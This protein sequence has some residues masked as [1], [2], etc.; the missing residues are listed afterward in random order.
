M[1][2]IQQL[3]D[4]FKFSNTLDNRDSIAKTIIISHIFANFCELYVLVSVLCSLLL[5]IYIGLKILVQL[6]KVVQE[7]YASIGGSP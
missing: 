3:V 6:R 4:F 7:Q 1:Q 2:E 5:Q